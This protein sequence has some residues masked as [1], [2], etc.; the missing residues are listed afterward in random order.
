MIHVF[1]PCHKSQPKL[2]LEAQRKWTP[3]SEWSIS[4]MSMEPTQG[5]ARKPLQ[6]CTEVGAGTP[7]LPPE[8]QVRQS[9]S[10][11]RLTAAKAITRAT[12]CSPPGFIINYCLAKEGRVWLKNTGDLKAGGISRTRVGSQPL[13]TAINILLAAGLTA[14]TIPAPPLVPQRKSAQ[15]RMA[16]MTGCAYERTPCSGKPCFSSFSCPYLAPNPQRPKGDFKDANHKN[17]V[18]VWS[19]G[20]T[21]AHN[22]S[23]L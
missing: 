12:S 22:G 23:R 14:T 21:I 7:A 4:P 5:K 17:G 1:F 15:P 16:K 3:A 6:P 19:L 18:A 8:V 9:T 13:T 10:T 11:C 20:R 2:D